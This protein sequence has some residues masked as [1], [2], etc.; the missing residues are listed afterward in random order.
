MHGEIYHQIGSLLPC[1]D[2]E[3]QFSQVLFYDTTFDERERRGQILRKSMG[4]EIP[5]QLLDQI[6]NELDKSNRL[7]KEFRPIGRDVLKEKEA[8][9]I[10][11]DDFKKIQIKKGDAKLYAL[12]EGD[13]IGAV[14]PAGEKTGETFSRNIIIQRKDSKLVRI[15]E[16]HSACH[17]LGYVLLHPT[18]QP[19]WSPDHLFEMTDSKSK[20][21]NAEEAA[22]IEVK[23]N[24]VHSQISS[25]SVHSE[26]EFYPP[27]ET[28]VNAQLPDLSDEGPKAWRSITLMMYMKFFLYIRKDCFNLLFKGLLF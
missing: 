25:D 27:A 14:V 10:I 9:M 3:K 2:K 21:P 7:Y 5:S 24:Q 11:V 22:E 20:R 17:P 15:S 1:N 26:L 23:Y 19:G 16:S 28:F 4:T 6:Q 12:P 13:D 18:G 8:K